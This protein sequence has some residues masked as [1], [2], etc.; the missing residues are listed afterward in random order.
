MDA[1]NKIAGVSFVKRNIGTIIGLI[2][3]VIIV[4]ISTPRFLTS[5]NILNLLKSNSVN[6]IISCGMLL[7]ILMGEID[8]SVGSTVGLS[9]IIGAYMITN[10]GLPV[11][12]L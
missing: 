3:L 11:V 1:K 8:I 7:A 12:H 9:G 5:S 2:L 10:V 6:A 4:S